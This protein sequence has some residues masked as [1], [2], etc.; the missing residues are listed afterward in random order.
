MKVSILGPKL[1]RLWAKTPNLLFGTQAQ[2]FL[3]SRFV[4]HTT[5]TVLQYSSFSI[6]NGFLVFRA[7]PDFTFWL[8]NK[9]HLSQHWAVEEPATIIYTPPITDRSRRQSV[10]GAVT[11]VELYTY[12]LSMVSSTSDKC[13]IIR[14]GTWYVWYVSSTL[15]CLRCGAVSGV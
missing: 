13:I 5:T 9:E 4:R 2:G 10:L 12:L 14:T 7:N 8:Q 3:L 11:T 1:L 15:L 6:K